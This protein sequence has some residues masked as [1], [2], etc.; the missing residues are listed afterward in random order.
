MASTAGTPQQ[1]RWY[2]RSKRETC[3]ARGGVRFTVR[4]RESQLHPNPGE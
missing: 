3:A 1:K 2:Q 4:H